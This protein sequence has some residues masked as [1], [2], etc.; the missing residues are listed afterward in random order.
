LKIN[1]TVFV[2]VFTGFLSETGIAH[3][4]HGQWMK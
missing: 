2:V 1:S 4:K 3:G